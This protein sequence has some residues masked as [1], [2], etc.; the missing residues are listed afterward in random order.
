MTLEMATFHR[1]GDDAHEYR[2]VR[3]DHNIFGFV[4]VETVGLLALPD[5]CHRFLLFRGTEQE[6]RE[7]FAKYVKSLRDEGFRTCEP[8]PQPCIVR[9]EN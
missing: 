4:V 3:L 2:E 7:F 1:R 9:S 6:A 5:E 8:E